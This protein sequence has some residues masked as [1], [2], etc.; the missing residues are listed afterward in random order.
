[1]GLQQSACCLGVIIFYWYPFH[2]IFRDFIERPLHNF[3]SGFEIKKSIRYLQ[4]C[5]L[6][7]HIYA[8]HVSDRIHLSTCCNQRKAKLFFEEIFKGLQYADDILLCR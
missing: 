8:N 3:T 5:F 4:E 7:M 1:M 2:L 6:L